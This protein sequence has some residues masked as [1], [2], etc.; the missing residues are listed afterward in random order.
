MRMNMGHETA[1]VF[2]WIIYRFD[3]ANLS[4]AT[5]NQR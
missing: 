1:I 3:V 4:I 2:D 5:T